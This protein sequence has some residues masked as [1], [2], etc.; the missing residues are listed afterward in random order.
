M[1]N[2]CMKCSEKDQCERMSHL[3]KQ[4][5]VYQKWKAS[6]K[7][8]VE[9]KRQIK[10]SM[11]QLDFKNINLD[12][13]PNGV[14]QDVAERI[15]AWKEVGGKEADSYILQELISLKMEEMIVNDKTS[16]YQKP[17]CL[18]KIGNNKE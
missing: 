6:C 16:I 7:R 4:G 17:L 11:E 2:P 8:I 13:I 14:L 3:C 12:I 18:K 5:K 1:I 15:V 9:C 10:K